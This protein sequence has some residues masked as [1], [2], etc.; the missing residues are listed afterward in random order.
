MGKSLDGTELGKGLGQRKDKKYFARVQV[1]GVRRE[2]CYNT[3]TEAK[4]GLR[5]LKAAAVKDGTLPNNITV[6]AWF[7]Q[8]QE[9]RRPQLAPRTL[10]LRAGLYNKHIRPAIGHMRLNAVTPAACQAVLTRLSDSHKASSI[11]R[12]LDVL[13]DLFRV[14]MDNR[15]ITYNPVNTGV[16]VPRNA[17]KSKP[18]QIPSAAEQADFLEAITGRKHEAIYRFAL[19]TGLRVGELTGLCWPD[20]DL[21]KHTL[22]V[23]RQLY[24]DHVRGAVH[25]PAYWHFAP[26]KTAAGVRSLPLTPEACRILKG[27]RALPQITHETPENMRDLIFLDGGWPV[28]ERRLDAHLDY[29]CRTCGL[30]H[31]SMHT[32]RH[33]F[34]S[35][36]VEA[37]APIPALSAVMGHSNPAVTLGIYVHADMASVAAMVAQMGTNGGKVAEVDAM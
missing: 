10:A 21:D 23:K 8:W 30:P 32:L 1:N 14:A 37:G 33:I 3:L 5:A 26:P 17:A 29:L 12:V 18:K 28:P 7:V 35:R 25:D 4:K 22:C 16:V 2:Y 31:I 13:R 20:V 27:L 24:C 9:I 36:A 11:K 19:E 15:V 34:A 6:N